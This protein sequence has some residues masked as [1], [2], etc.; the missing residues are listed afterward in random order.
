DGL[1]AHCTRLTHRC[2][3]DSVLPTISAMASTTSEPFPPLGTA[4]DRQLQSE[5]NAAARRRRK[6]SGLGQDLRVGDTGAPALATS[7]AHLHGSPQAKV[8]S[9]V[10]RRSR[11]RQNQDCANR[12]WPSQQDLTSGK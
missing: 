2:A 3:S 10:E 9:F 8:S 12:R 1:L 6:S 5:M 11:I 7:L 4:A